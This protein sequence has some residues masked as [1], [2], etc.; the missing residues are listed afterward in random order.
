MGKKDT[1][2][3][4][5]DSYVPVGRGGKETGITEKSG[6]GGCDGEF[7]GPTWLGHGN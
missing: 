4:Q 5:D 1:P 7:Y 6:R 3:L 2:Q